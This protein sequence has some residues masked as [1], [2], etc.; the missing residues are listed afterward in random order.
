MARL[1]TTG[2]GRRARRRRTIVL[3]AIVLLLLAGVAGT[4]LGTRSDRARPVG[5]APVTRHPPAPTPP[6]V[7]T[8]LGRLRLGLDENNAN[9]L[10]APAARAVPAALEPWRRRL[11]ALRPS[12]LRFVIDWARLA[13]SP[14]RAPTWD[15]PEDGCLRGLPPCGAYG[16]V[17][18]RLL[19]VA[20]LRRAGVA[21]EPVA[22]ID[23]APAWAAGPP[24]GCEAQDATVSARPLNARGLSAYRQLVASL[25]SEA[26][27]DGAELR[28]LSPW[29]EP[30]NPRF[31][32]PQ[33][34][35]C[36][37]TAPSLAVSVYAQLA[38]A[39]A[40]VL[41]ADGSAHRLLLGDL[42]AYPSSGARRTGVAQFVA[43]LPRDVLCLGATWALHVYASPAAGPRGGLAPVDALLGA[44]RARGRCGSSERVWITETG[45]GA[46]HPGAP[47][48]GSATEQL[49]GCRALAHALGL[50]RTDP[51]VDAVLQYTFREDTRFPVG[52]ADAGLTR[53][54][55]TYGLLRAFSMGAADPALVGACDH[56]A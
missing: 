45:A 25:L 37:A 54:Y 15:A 48:R 12:V 33:H 51:A 2:A 38:R 16:G 26:R 53:R 52:L 42:A 47:R 24:G 3:G 10:F 39:M 35:T 27:R 18:D 46:L 49:R 1:S 23:D 34:A 44:L 30:D 41:A 21:V 55:P 31:I 32:T 8:A 43:E 14:N 40:S 20:S 56:A 22:V 6:P 7:P 5:R 36:S 50:W 9:L 13:P 28:Y 29:N 19:A 17:R 11:L 4:R